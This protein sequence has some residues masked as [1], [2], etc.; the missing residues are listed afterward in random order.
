[1]KYAI[2]GAGANGMLPAYLLK[3]AGHDVQVVTEHEEQAA[4]INEQ[5]IIHGKD[6]QYI[7]AYTDIEQIDPDAFILLTVKYEDLQPIL[8]LLKIR[9]PSNRIVF[10]QQGMLFLE[11]ARTLSHR[12]IAAAV[13]ETDCVK[14]S[15]TEISFNKTAHVTYGLVK[16]HMEEFQPLLE[17]SAWQTNWVETIEEQLFESL[18][19][20]SLID[21]LTALMKIRNGELIT[22]PHA[23]ELF[24]NLYNELYLA[25]PEI[26]SLQPIEKVAAFCAAEPERASAM[27]TDRLAG[28]PMEVEG[29]MLYVLNR[30]KLELPLFKA[31]YHLLKTVEVEK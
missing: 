21:P 10:L 11:K 31:F 25:F 29:L 2:I 26:E 1:M 12:H 27:L 8:R 3:K 4:S 23:Y 30:S 17:S 9:C 28:D 13:L 7:K 18:L 14:L 15:N 6:R 5:G 22:N 19:F 20:S 24:R 16:G